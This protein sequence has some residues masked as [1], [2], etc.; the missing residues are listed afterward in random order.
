VCRCA[1]SFPGRTLAVTALSA[2]SSM[3]PLTVAALPL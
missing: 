1:I 3:L 2:G